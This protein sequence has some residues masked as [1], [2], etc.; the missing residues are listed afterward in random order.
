MLFRSILY[1]L[2]GISERLNVG[3]GGDGTTTVNSL[4]Q[5]DLLT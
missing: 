2:L 4:F 1:V 5:V 3:E